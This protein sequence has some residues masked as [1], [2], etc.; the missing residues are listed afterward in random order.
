MPAL[1]DEDLAVVGEHDARALERPR[2]RSFEVDPGRPEAAAVTRALE[3]VLRRQEVR[4]AAQM[5]ARGDEGVEPARVRTMSSGVRTSQMPNFSF[6]R[7]STPIPYSFGK[8]A[9]NCC[10]GSLSTFGNMKRPVAARAAADAAENAPHARPIHARRVRSGEVV[11]IARGRLGGRC[12]A[13]ALARHRP[14]TRRWWFYRRDPESARPAA[15]RHRRTRGGRTS[16]GGR[17]GGLRRS[18]RSDR[19][20]PAGGAL[21]SIPSTFVSSAMFV[22]RSLSGP[23][24]PPSGLHAAIALAQCRHRRLERFVL[25]R[26]RRAQSADH[27]VRDRILIVV[28]P[29][30]AL[31]RLLDV[32]AIEHLPEHRH[33]VVLTFPR[34]R[35]RGV[36]A[37]VVHRVLQRRAKNRQLRVAGQRTSA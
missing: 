17:S 25:E 18:S 3:L 8:P 5:R 4:R 35:H 2:R 14:A 19:F 15:R 22:I 12:G 16:R 27:H 20:A 37:H 21:G 9:L 28:L 29:H 11:G 36:P 23:R 33:A 26:G 31:H 1:V 13:A 7:S 34:Q 6:H 24:S 32:A 30:V 10:G